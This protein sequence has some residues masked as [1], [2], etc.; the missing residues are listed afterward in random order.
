MSVY[1]TRLFTRRKAIDDPATSNEV[2]GDM[3]DGVLKPHLYNAIVMP[4]YAHGDD[5]IE[6][7]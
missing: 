5:K 4:D 1:S 6:D 7:I 2:L 3:L